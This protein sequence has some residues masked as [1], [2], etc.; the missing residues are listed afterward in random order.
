MSIQ[1]V[2]VK[3]LY[4]YIVSFIAL[5]VVLFNLQNFLM[6]SAQY[7]IFKT[8]PDY[9]YQPQFFPNMPVPVSPRG[10]MMEG[11]FGVDDYQ[12]Q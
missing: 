10:M 2:T 9:T 7:L 5:L 3:Q 12:A 4:F 6:V 8:V 1:H 11:K